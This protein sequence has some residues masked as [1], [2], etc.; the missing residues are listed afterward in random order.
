MVLLVAIGAGCSSSES[1]P[2]AGAG[3]TAGAAGAP[4]TDGSTGCP[5]WV[6]TQA[7][8]DCI[9]QKCGALAATA[10]GSGW[11]NDNPYGGACATFA[12]CWCACTPGNMTCVQTCYAQAGSVCQQAFTPF[13]TCETQNCAAPVCP[14]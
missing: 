13:V 2:N 11:K 5:G 8:K 9:D 10:L 6:P 14:Q 1:A 7:C 4:G 12:Q 3:G